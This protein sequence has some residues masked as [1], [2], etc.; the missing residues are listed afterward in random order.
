MARRGTDEFVVLDEDGEASDYGLWIDV[1]NEDELPDFKDVKK[2]GGRRRNATRKDVEARREP[3][4]RSMKA[5]LKAGFAAQ[6]RAALA[7]FDERDKE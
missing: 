7:T 4:R 5:Q 6:E 3:W 2:P 1:F